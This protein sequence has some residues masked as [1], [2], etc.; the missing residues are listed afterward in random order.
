[1]LTPDSVPE[2][3]LLAHRTLL[4]GLPQAVSV[5]DSAGAHRYTNAAA[6][7]ILADVHGGPGGRAFAE[8]GTR[9]AAAELPVEITRLTGRECDNAC[10]G[11]ADAAG[12]VRWLRIS[13]RRLG[14][15]AGPHWVLASLQDVTE[16]R[17]TALALGRATQQFQSAFDNA[18]IGMAL[19]GL[20]GQWLQVNQ[21]L[22]ELV[23]YSEQELL[24]RPSRTSPT[25]TT[26]TTI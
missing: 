7:A 13:T 17:D 16:A 1:M 12:H 11:F 22:C 10:V 8:D 2:P 3:D 5:T 4:D 20:E 21:A 15:G 26:S 23:G 18:S 9:L 14:G 25:R 19:V 24:G 6:G